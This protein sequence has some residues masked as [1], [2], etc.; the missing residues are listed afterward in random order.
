MRQSAQ[1]NGVPRTPK[2]RH[3]ILYFQVHQPR[4]LRKLGFLDIGHTGDYFDEQLNKEIISRVSQNCY[5]PTNKMLRK[6][7]EKLPN[8]KLCFSLS[9]VLIDQLE[10]Y[11]PEALQSFKDL[12]STG[13]VEFLSE[14]YYH[15]LSSLTPNEEFIIQV[16]AHRTLMEHHFGMYPE[17]FRNTELIYSNSIGSKVAQLGFKGIVCDGNGR[18]LNGK[19]PYQ[20]YK[21]ASHERFNILLRSNRLS[22]DI[23]FRFGNDANKFTVDD[24]CRW[25]TNIP[26][27]EN[28]ITLG[29]DYET[30]GEH[31]R[32][33]TGIITFLEKLITKLETDGHTTLTT[34]SELLRTLSPKEKL[35]IHDFVS[36][37][38]ESKDI[39]AWLGND[40]Q[41][42]AFKTLQS[43]EESILSTQNAEMIETWRNL[44]TSD[45]FYYMCTKGSADANVHAYFS[46]YG[47]PYE[48]FINYMNTLTDLSLRAR[49]PIGPVKVSREAKSAT[50]ESYLFA[51]PV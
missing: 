19:N 3:V 21:H 12:A 17:V 22:D 43:L 7:T 28:V 5:L 31:F 51:A 38:D 25:I 8:V 11:Q 50:P 15:S 42:D 47:S 45:H 39:S 37:A 44:Q 30:F 29:M 24:Y 14:T 26:G 32:A 16:Q 10:K 40:I 4:R 48:A 34:P 20:I 2:E 1:A 35:D 46:H 41:C 6:L 23:A 33:S 18:T 13:A 27:D 36:W 49:T 9:G